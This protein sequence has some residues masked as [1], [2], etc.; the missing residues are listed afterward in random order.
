MPYDG[1][2]PKENKLRKIV[3]NLLNDGADAVIALTDVYTGQQRF[4]DAADAKRK[5]REWVGNEPRFY[6]HAAQHEFE[7]WL[8]PFW[9]A[10][11]RLSGSD[12]A[13]PPGQPERVNHMNPPSKWIS[14]AFQT[15]GRREY[16]KVRDAQRI[17]EGQDLHVAID[18][19]P[20]LKSLVNTILRLCGGDPV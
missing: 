14:E 5:L 9:P 10:V 3:Q 16:N 13:T 19:C 12:R 17:L 8:L 4:E 2:I 11:R 20:E 15:G 18:A 7:A 1:L 6:A